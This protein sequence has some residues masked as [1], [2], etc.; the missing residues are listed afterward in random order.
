MFGARP[1]STVAFNL[2]NVGS[3]VAA[4]GTAGAGGLGPA[5]MRLRSSGLDPAGEA[6]VFTPGP[7]FLF[8]MMWWFLRCKI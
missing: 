7:G 1:V 2:M 8:R 4:H 3:G 6:P 5:R